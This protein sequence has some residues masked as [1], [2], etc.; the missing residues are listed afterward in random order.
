MPPKIAVLGAAGMLGHKM[1]QQ[2]Y[3]AFPGAIG[4]VRR[5]PDRWPLSGEIVSGVDAAEWDRFSATLRRVR[6]H[7]TV[8]CIGII[9]QRPDAQNP[10]ALIAI[11]ALLPH[12]LAALCGEWGGRLI[13][14]STDCVFSGSRGGY[15]EDDDSDAR[16]LYGKTKFLG[17][18][19]AANTLVLRTSIIGREC[20]GRRSLLEWFLA[21]RGQTVRGFSHVI[22]SGV[23]TNHAACLVG[24]IIRGHPGLTGL[25]QVAGNPISKYDLLNRLRIAFAL[26]VEIVPDEAE[27]SDRSMCGEK[28]RGAIGYEPPSW[29][30]MI[31][32]LSTDPTP[33]ESRQRT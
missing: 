29:T 9:K 11:N 22:W 13:H 2:L 28:L 17:E 8:N 31:H 20:T 7:F 6:P 18:V 21:Q 5:L 1:Y 24:Q 32:E 26:P 12:R 4:I 25:Y 14:F 3:R 10:A 30:E 23:T 15:R 16:D 19:R 33:Y 27:R